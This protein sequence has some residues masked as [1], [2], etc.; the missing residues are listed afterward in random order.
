MTTPPP[1]SP[2]SD[3]VTDEEAREAAHALAVL[4]DNP[5][6]G[7]AT[8]PHT[9]RCDSL[10]VIVQARDRQRQAALRAQLVAAEAAQLRATKALHDIAEGD[11]FPQGVARA[12]LRD[13]SA[14]P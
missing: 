10:V 14:K 11:N 13:L 1:P 2:V 12:A 7:T 8:F 5:C 9:A 6:G 4:C 3:A